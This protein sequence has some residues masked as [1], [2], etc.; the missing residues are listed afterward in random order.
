[1][2]TRILIFSG[3]ILVVILT[4]CVQQK[5]EEN[6]AIAK[7]ISECKGRLALGEDL[8][9]GPCI[10]DDIYPSWVCDVAHSP[11]QQ[12]DNIPENQCSAFRDG[13]ANHFVEVDEGCNLIR[14][15]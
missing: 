11:R 12:V 5:S 10:S 15:L 7:C 14:A 2:K 13:K 4:G 8:K 1:M 9:N 3:L 6:P